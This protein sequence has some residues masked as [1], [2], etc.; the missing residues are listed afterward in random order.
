ML[1]CKAAGD[2]VC[3]S[4]EKDSRNGEDLDDGVVT[5]VKIYYVLCR[6]F[7]VVRPR[8]RGVFCFCHCVPLPLPFN[9]TNLHIQLNP[10]FQRCQFL[11][12]SINSNPTHRQHQRHSLILIVDIT[13]IPNLTITDLGESSR[14]LFLV[15]NRRRSENHRFDVR[16]VGR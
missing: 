7:F 5:K 6:M 2:R 10:C 16:A 13:N 12:P 15:V 14:R 11:E 9:G 1:P 8:C 4:G 3:S